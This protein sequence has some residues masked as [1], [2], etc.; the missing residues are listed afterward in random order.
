[1]TPK[2]HIGDRV[3]VRVGEPPGHFRTPTYIQG[4]TGDIEAIHGAFPDP[5]SLAHGGDGLPA[6]VLYLVRFDQTRVWEDY[7]ASPQDR[8][9]IDLYEPWLEP[10]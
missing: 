6:Q 3:R 4:K 9:L 7:A 10:V 8:L 5:E 2:F 1:M